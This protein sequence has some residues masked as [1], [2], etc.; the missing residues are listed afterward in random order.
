MVA[1]GKIKI[2]GDEALQKAIRELPRA[3]QNKIIRPVLVKASKPVLDGARSAVVKKKGWLKRSLG[4]KTKTYKRGGVAVIVGA[5]R[6]MAP[7]GIEPANYAHLVEKGTKPHAVGKGSNSRK[8]VLGVQAA[9][10]GI[11]PGAKAQ[12]FL[13]P[14]LDKNAAAIQATIS[15]GLREGIERETGVLYRG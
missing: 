15:N 14:A 2:E 7:D 3:V 4:R 5:R 11:H 6:G 13:K 8:S 1:L 10:G 12:P 9:H